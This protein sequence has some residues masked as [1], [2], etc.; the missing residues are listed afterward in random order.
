MLTMCEG[1]SQLITTKLQTGWVRSCA[2]ER[3]YTKTVHLEARH[4]DVT[5]S[6]VKVTSR[7]RFSG[8]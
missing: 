5:I 8:C 2:G 4:N 7:R 3:Q 1:M 6:I